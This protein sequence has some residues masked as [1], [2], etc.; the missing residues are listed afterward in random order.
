M[1][2]SSYF[3]KAKRKRSGQMKAERAK[4]AKKKIKF[5]VKKRLINSWTMDIYG[6]LHAGKSILTGEDS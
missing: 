6:H 3:D 5:Y 1:R 2:P 4:L